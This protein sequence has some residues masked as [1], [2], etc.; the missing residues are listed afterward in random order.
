[1]EY[2]LFLGDEPPEQST[3][4]FHEHRERA[5]HLEQG[6][7]RGRLLAAADAVSRAVGRSG[8]TRIVDLGCGDGGLM[9]LVRD[10]NPGVT[11]WGYDF[12]PANVAGWLERGVDGR[13]LDFVKNLD[14]IEWAPIVVM[15]E[16]AEHLHDPHGVV[17]E[18]ARHADHV[19]M[20]SP[21]NEH[22]GSHDACHV[23][24]WDMEGY[25]ALLHQAGFIVEDHVTAG[26]FQI[27]WGS[28]VKE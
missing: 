1:M 27:I 19:I 11:V 20:S 8:H 3:F 18:I 7:H 6:G 2:R 23:W 10:E 26:Q 16:C 21:W 14:K 24:A 17:R 25:R 5:P 4:E 12:A 15:T 13:A 9:S 22:A 28:N